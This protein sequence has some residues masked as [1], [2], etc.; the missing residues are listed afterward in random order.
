LQSVQMV[1][2]SGKGHGQISKNFVSI[3]S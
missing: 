2:G 3:I 1:L